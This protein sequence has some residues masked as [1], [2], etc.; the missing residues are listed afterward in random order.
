MRRI[1]AILLR[2]GLTLG[3]VHMRRMF[4]SSFV[5]VGLVAC[6]ETDSEMGPSAAGGAKTSTAGGAAMTA[7]GGSIALG[8]GSDAAPEPPMYDR[9]CIAARL[10][11]TTPSAGAEHG[12]TTGGAG[13][14]GG[15]GLD[16]GGEGGSGIDLELGAGDLTLLVLFDK[17]GSMA[18]GWDERSKWQVANESF[19][20][21][22]EPVLQNLTIGTI[23]FPQPGGCAV[24]ALDSGLQMS[25]APGQ[26][27]ATSWQETAET[28]I[29][30]GSTPLE[31]SFRYADMAIER[32]CGFG[33]LDDRFRVVLITDGEPTCSDDTDA[34]IELAA[35]WHA[36]GVETWVMGLPG[37]SGAA[38]L[39]DAIA[40]A[41]GTEK[42]MSLGTPTELDEGLAAAAK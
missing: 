30:E 19:M 7:Q 3:R 6:G 35:E 13:G 2:L 24:A 16:S 23:F 4:A 36:L 10:S 33:L 17:S 20:K 18:G 31:L 15:A 14:A 22:I 5:I 25:Y 11:T 27:F 21:A 29:P 41:G 1:A 32:G 26:K 39:L 40:A 42:A 28:R 9:S 37:S 34:V 12:A 38:Q 8:A